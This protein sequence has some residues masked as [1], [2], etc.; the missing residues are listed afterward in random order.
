MIVCD[1]YPAISGSTTT[2]KTV[3]SNSS[4]APVVLVT[5]GSGLVGSAIEEVVKQ[6]PKLQERYHFVFIG[7]G[8]GDLAD[9]DSARRL[10][11]KQVKPTYVIHLAAMVGGLFRN[12]KA[13]LDFFRINMAINDNVLAAAHELKC[14]KT[15]SCLSTCIFP[16][17]TTYPI[18]ETMVSIL[19]LL[20]IV[21]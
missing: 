7:T 13:N 2:M 20:A 9:K 4:S 11:V 8:D 17:K 18:D 5:G 6:D 19:M 21:T 14:K 1:I 12:M 15:I 10:I 3:G 16:D